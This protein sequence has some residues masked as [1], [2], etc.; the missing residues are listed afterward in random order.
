MKRRAY[1]A[2]EVKNVALDE[3][4]RAAPPGAATAGLDIG[5]YAIYGDCS[6]E[7]ELFSSVPSV[8]E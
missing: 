2:A 4:M 7:M 3:V 8:V 5:K 1:R 6:K